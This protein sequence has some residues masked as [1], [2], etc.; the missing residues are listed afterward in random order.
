MT[1]KTEQERANFEAW[2][3]EEGCYLSD[4]SNKAAMFAAYQ[5]GRLGLQT[6]PVAYLTRDEDG[7]PAML[8]FDLDE[9]RLYCNPNEEPE[10][11]VLSGRSQ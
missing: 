7:S 2:W 1:T 8:F 11:L 5:A 3:D 10:P 6:E 9:A 4:L